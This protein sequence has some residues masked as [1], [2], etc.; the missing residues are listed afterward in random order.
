M[1]GH[2][3]VPLGYN[4]FAVGGTITSL[5]GTVGQFIIP[6]QANRVLMSAETAALRWRDDN[7][8]LAATVGFLL[9]VSLSPFDYSGNLASL[10]FISSTGA[11]GV[12]NVA[13]YRDVG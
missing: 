11:P 6:A 4:Q 3:Y 9:P 12:L 10:R 8:P 5:T 7:G 1:E 13:Y 2:Q